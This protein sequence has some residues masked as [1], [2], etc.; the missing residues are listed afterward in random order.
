[1]TLPLH[2]TSRLTDEVTEGGVDPAHEDDY[3][4]DGVEDVVCQSRR[5]HV[6]PEVRR[7]VH[8]RQEV[9]ERCAAAGDHTSDDR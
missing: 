3:R 4:E 5:A 6:L 2:E 9:G 7:V 1:M 8:K